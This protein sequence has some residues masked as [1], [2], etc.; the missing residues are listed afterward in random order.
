[1]VENLLK[2][3]ASVRKY[4]Y[5]QLTKEEVSN[6]IEV[7][8]HAAS[9]HFVQAYSVIW[10]SDKEKRMELGRLSKNPVQF[11]TAGAALLLCVDFKRLQE[12]GKLHQTEITIDTVENLLVGAVD[13]SLFAQNLV[14]AAESK[15]Y[16]ICYIGGVRNAPKEVSELVGLPEG[17]F[18][19]FGITLGV[20]AQQNDVKPR[21][22]VAAILHENEYDY[23]KYGQLLNEYDQTMQEY[24]ANRG[25]NQK[26]SSWTEQMAEFLG[27]PRRE[28]MAAFLAS[29]GFHLK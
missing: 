18:P 27:K 26:Q 11:E 12:A 29:K 4:K 9:S 15:G 24:Y 1:M 22:P 2:S 21:L 7:A 19:L 5:I 28:H 8:Q 6:L 23:S 10:I 16:G 17:V 13:V 14:I 3:H 20:P 25:S